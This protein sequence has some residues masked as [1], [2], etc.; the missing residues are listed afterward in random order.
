LQVELFQ[1]LLLCQPCLFQVLL[2]KS[3]VD[4]LLLGGLWSFLHGELSGLLV[5]R[6]DSLHRRTRVR[7][8][9]GTIQ[10]C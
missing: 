8:P 5:D 1:L 10:A 3:Q 6:G 7:A 9:Q 2:I 4:T